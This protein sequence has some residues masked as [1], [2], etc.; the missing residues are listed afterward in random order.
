M[1]ET[2]YFRLL[3]F[4][5]GLDP[6]E[7][8]IDGEAL[9]SICWHDFFAFCKKQT[10]AGLAFEGV[11]RLPKNVAPP[12]DVLMPWYALSEQIRRQSLVLDKATAYVYRRITAAGYA[13][14]ILKGQGN[15][16]MYPVPTSRMPGDVDVWVQA[17]RADIR[18]LAERLC[19]AG[20]SKD[21]ETLNHVSIRL[22]GVTIELHHTPSL[23]YSPLHNGRLQRWLRAEA[24]AQCA[25]L[26]TL[27]DGQGRAAVPDDRFNAVY[28]LCHLYHHFLFEG[29]GLRQFVD[30][31][32]V[33][34]R[35][36]TMPDYRTDLVRQFR[37]LGLLPFAGAVMYVLRE[38][39]AMDEEDMPVLPNA[40]RGRLLLRE[41]LHGGNFGHYNTENG[42]AMTW[43]HNLF[44]LR[45]DV[46]LVRYYPWECLAEPFF[47]LYN[48]LW[49]LGH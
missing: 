18:R 32:Y 39:M 41:I 49:R 28:Q 5:L 25:H 17:S 24:A 48:F 45:R 35:V 30:Y 13:C 14:C 9:K 19:E 47:R 27:S 36:S 40:R 12:R 42:A 3:R 6:G 20:G 21:E 46:Q 1:D 26:V 43:R 15:A 2:L 10:L 38:V 33:I 37:R 23:F 44:R 7:D 29:V 16:L 4:S 31:Y 34:R 11:R 22:R 8:I